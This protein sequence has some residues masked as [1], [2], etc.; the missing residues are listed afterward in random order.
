MANWKIGSSNMWLFDSPCYS[1]SHW[2]VFCLPVLVPCCGKRPVMPLNHQYREAV[3]EQ[4]STW[5]FG[6]EIKVCCKINV[7]I[8][9]A[10]LTSRTQNE[11]CSDTQL[12]VSQHM[13]YND[14][15]YN[16]K[17]VFNSES[18]TP[19]P[20]V[21]FDWPQPDSISFCYRRWF[22]SHP[23]HFRLDIK[24]KHDVWCSVHIQNFKTLC[25]DLAFHI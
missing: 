24:L 21:T 17:L 4:I 25:Y 20:F 12:I 7:D 8:Q 5:F 9:R 14:N 3:D 15:S 6:I 18:Q 11:S 22:S 19:A 23:S 1:W 10:M 13:M 16:N 2:W